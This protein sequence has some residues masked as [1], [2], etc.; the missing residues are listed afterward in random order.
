M[1]IKA[2]QG[3]RSIAPEVEKLLLCQVTHSTAVRALHII[4]ND[5]HGSQQGKMMQA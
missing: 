1:L 3:K 2:S 5:L 4:R